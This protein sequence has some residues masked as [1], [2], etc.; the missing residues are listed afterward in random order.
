[1]AV[2][3]L[4]HCLDFGVPPGMITVPSSA[5]LDKGAESFF[6]GMGTHKADRHPLQIWWFWERWL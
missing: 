1:M 3:M 5:D 6:W 4:E 2:H